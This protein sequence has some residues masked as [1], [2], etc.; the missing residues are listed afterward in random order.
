ML[1]QT[2]PDEHVKCMVCGNVILHPSTER[3]MDVSGWICDEC[4]EDEPYYA[5]FMCEC[6]NCGHKFGKGWQLPQNAR[7]KLV[8]PNRLTCPKCKK[9]TGIP[10]HAVT[11][12]TD[13]EVEGEEDWVD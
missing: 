7:G 2:N 4:G 9:R 11:Y 8:T 1:E 5:G 3:N 13:L 10:Q 12:G 6:E